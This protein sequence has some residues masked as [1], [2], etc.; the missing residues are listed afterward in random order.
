MLMYCI[1]NVLDKVMSVSY[2]HLDVYKRQALTLCNRRTYC[3]PLKNVNI[4][5][6][7]PLPLWRG[8]TQ[9]RGEVTVRNLGPVASSTSS[10]TAW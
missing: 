5:S 6:L 7:N 3:L 4:D 8:S 2:T 9:Y 10:A 1:S